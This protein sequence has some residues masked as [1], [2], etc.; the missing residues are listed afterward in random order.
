MPTDDTIDLFESTAEFPPESTEDVDEID[1]DFAPRPKQRLGKSTVLLAAVLLAGLG[2]LGG[3]QVQKSRATTGTQAGALPGGGNFRGGSFP[4]GLTLPGGFNQ[5]GTGQS[6]S[7]A[8]SG[9]AV[10]GTVVSVKGHTL[11]VKNFA[12]KT[13]TVTLADDTP[14]TQTVKAAALRTGQSV[15]V[16]GTTGADGT[17]TA[18]QVTAR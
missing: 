12:G 18:T 11:T 5:P 3:V 16:S 14:I 10:I 17:V 15:T 2:F 1:A 7:S 13:I 8:T 9:P 6:S 4:S